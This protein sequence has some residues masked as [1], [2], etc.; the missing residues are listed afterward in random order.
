MENMRT[1][2]PQRE[3]TEWDSDDYLQ[4]IWNYVFLISLLL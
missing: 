2:F 1:E 4:M 3:K